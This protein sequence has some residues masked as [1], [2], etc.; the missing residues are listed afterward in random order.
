M[1]NNIKPKNVI[2]RNIMAMNINAFVM[3]YITIKLK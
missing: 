3:I 1:K 2:K